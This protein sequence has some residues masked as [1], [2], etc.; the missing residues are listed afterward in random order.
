MESGRQERGK[1]V[2]SKAFETL[3]SE[4][5]LQDGNCTVKPAS[6]RLRRNVK[7]RSMT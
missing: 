3:I 5:M 2:L 6:R 1:L 4:V 7:D